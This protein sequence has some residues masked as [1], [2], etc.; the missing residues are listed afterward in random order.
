MYG[1][2]T[3]PAA[4]LRDDRDWA[5]P[6]TGPLPIEGEPL[7]GPGL[8][9]WAGGHRVHQTQ[10][11]QLDAEKVAALAC[12]EPIR[13]GGENYWPEFLNLHSHWIGHCG[14]A[15]FM[16][17]YEVVSAQKLLLGFGYDGPVRLWLDSREIHSDRNGINPCVPDHHT[18]SVRLTP[19]R[20]RL[21][22]AID[23]NGGGAWGFALRWLQ[24]GKHT[25]PVSYPWPVCALAANV[26][27]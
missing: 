6:V 8:V 5:I 17:E 27:D 7:R 13:N 3:N 12:Q 14:V 1:H 18:V 9:V 25:R 26:T 20:H 11:D 23:V 10:L 19:G 24:T 2:G 15:C 4:L 22:L 21:A 16:T